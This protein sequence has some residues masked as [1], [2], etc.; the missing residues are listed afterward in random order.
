M[1]VTVVK[2]MHMLCTNVHKCIL[3]YTHMQN[4]RSAYTVKARMSNSTD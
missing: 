2:M 4:S 3:V 1:V